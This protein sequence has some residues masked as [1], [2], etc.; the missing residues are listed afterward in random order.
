MGVG[1]GNSGSTKRAEI[2]PLPFLMSMARIVLE[3]IVVTNLVES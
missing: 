2:G 3:A 1:L